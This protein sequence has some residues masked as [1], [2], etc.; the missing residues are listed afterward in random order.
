MAPFT[1]GVPL[2]SFYGRKRIL[3]PI[4]SLS[5]TPKSTPTIRFLAQSTLIQPREYWLDVNDGCTVQY[6]QR[7]DPDT[8]RLLDLQGLHTVQADR[9]WSVC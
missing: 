9:V 3:Q 7:T 1:C 6:L 4:D 8:P 5:P 2:V